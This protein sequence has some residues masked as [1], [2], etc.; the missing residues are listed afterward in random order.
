MDTM[1]KVHAVMRYT[2][3]SLIVTAV[4]AAH[5]DAP[6]WEAFGIDPDAA[7]SATRYIE[8]EEGQF[9]MKEY[10][11]PQMFR[12]DL[13]FEGEQGTMIMRED[14]Q[15]A[16]LLMTS[17]NTYMEIPT[18]Q[19]LEAAF[20]PQVVE[21]IRVGRENVLG[22]DTTKYHGAFLDPDGIRST[23]YMWVTDHGIPIKMDM[24]YEE[25]GERGERVRM[26]LRDLQVGPQSAALFEVP[27]GYQPFSLGNI[28]NLLRGGGEPAAAQPA[29]P[30]SGSDQQETAR[31][32]APS[33]PSVAEEAA[34]AAADEARRTTVDE[35][36][37]ATQEGL[38]S[39][40]R[41]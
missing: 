9:E 17:M 7:Y 20:Y 29:A 35:A 39:I 37:R 32:P 6:S 27:E 34:D 18:D 1:H 36:R 10:R 15:I 40:F 25:P 5:A 21:R 8:S 41:R 16:Y 13:L 38:R 26:E 11:A 23:G 24:V 19:V 2:F 3:V 14:R 33:R 28:G 30:A 31:A 22:H 12:A 4:A